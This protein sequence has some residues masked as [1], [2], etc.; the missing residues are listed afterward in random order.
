MNG[1]S[2]GEESMTLCGESRKEPKSV[3]HLISPWEIS[4]IGTRNV[5]TMYGVGRTAEVIKYMMHFK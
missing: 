4:G 2:Y 5:R 3:I 1:G